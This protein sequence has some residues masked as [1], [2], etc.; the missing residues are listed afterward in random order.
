MIP[1]FFI[2]Y[3]NGIQIFSSKLKQAQFFAANTFKNFVIFDWEWTEKLVL[4]WN[5]KFFGINFFSDIKFRIE[6]NNFPN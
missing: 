1:I 2:I 5:Y 3:K 4:I 6:I